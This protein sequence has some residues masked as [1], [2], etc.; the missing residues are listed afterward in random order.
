MRRAAGPVLGAQA[1]DALAPRAA[2][3]ELVHGAPQQ[4][5]VVAQVAHLLDGPADESYR[6]LLMP[7]RI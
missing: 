7:T 2:P 6:Y 3:R 5:V 4:Q 1:Q